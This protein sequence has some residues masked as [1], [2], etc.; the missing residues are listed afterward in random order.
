[1]RLISIYPKKP[2]RMLVHGHVLWSTYDL[3]SK[4]KTLLKDQGPDAPRKLMPGIGC[5][6][7]ASKD[8]YPMKKTL[9]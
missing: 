7:S 9:R 6:V 1:M 3:P 4:A 2:P 8:I 5:E